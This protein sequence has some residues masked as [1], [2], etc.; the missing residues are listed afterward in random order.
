MSRRYA[1]KLAGIKGIVLD[2][3]DHESV[4]AL[5]NH[6][7]PIA[8]IHC[9]AASNVDWCEDH[10]DQASQINA[11]AAGWLAQLAADASA[12]FIYISTDSVFDGERGQYSETDQPNP[13]NAYARSKWM[14]EQ[15][16]LSRHSASAIVRTTI[17]GWNTQPK[18]SLPE[19]MYAQLQRGVKVPGFV[20]VF[21][22][23]LLVNDLAEI[24]LEMLERKSTGIFHVCAT[25]TLSKFEFG[26]RVANVF[27]FDPGGIVPATLDDAKLIARRPRNPSLRTSKIEAALGRAM[28]S[29][30]AGLQRFREIW[31]RGEV[32]A[33]KSYVEGASG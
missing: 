26:Q 20:D 5:V 24:L 21:F 27:G 33:W 2:L 28:P 17:Y 15:A 3:L 7:R 22:N 23:P 25:E 29:I 19:W 1:V 16:V 10:P 18:Q 9:A 6:L 14:G 4:Q 31:D 30:D 8:M 32:Q 13:I 12:Q 11:D